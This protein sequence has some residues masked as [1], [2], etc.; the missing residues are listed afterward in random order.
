MLQSMIP[1]SSA[2]GGREYCWGR[3]VKLPVPVL[4]SQCE[5]GP[6]I[7]AIFFQVLESWSH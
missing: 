4:Q 7:A 1:T 6:P 3:K 2:G 5:L